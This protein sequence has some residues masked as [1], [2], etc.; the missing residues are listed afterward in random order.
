MKDGKLELPT[1]LLLV[2]GMITHWPQNVALTSR[3][4]QRQEFQHVEGRVCVFLHMN[5]RN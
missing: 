3:T 4:N 2:P 5:A 1:A